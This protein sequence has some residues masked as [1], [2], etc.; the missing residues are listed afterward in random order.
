MSAPTILLTGARSARGAF[1]VL[2]RFE[3]ELLL[4]V[5]NATVHAF[6]AGALE[7]HGEDYR[8]YLAIYVRPVSR[9]TPAYMAL[10]DPFRRAFVYP[11]LIRRLQRAWPPG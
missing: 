5:R 10:I 1:R 9:W 6:L 3:R 8:L 7:P 4:E 2:Y 11:A